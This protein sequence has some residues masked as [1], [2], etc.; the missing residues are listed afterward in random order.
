MEIK[1]QGLIIAAGASSHGKTT[2]TSGLAR[3]LVN[4]GKKVKIFKCGPDFLDPQ[5]HK[6]ASGVDCDNLDARMGTTTEITNRVVNACKYFDVI[7]FEGVMGLY[8]GNPSAADLA[9]MFKLPILLVI[10]ARAMAS[11][12]G[13]LAFGLKY[14]KGETNKARKYIKYVFANRVGS[15]NHANICRES[16]TSD[17]SQVGF[18]ERSQDIA[19]PEQHLGL[20]PANEII[21][22]DIKLN[23]LAKSLSEI[24]WSKVFEN[25]TLPP[26]TTPTP[27]LPKLLEN[28]TIAIA[29]DRAFCFIY[30]AN[31]EILK[32][33][34]AK[35]KYFSPLSATK[36]P[37]CN[38]LWLP[39]GYPEIY[40]PELADNQT[41]QNEI[42]K[43]IINGKPTLAECGG[44]LYCFE[45]LIDINNSPHNFLGIFAGV[46]KM[47]KK[48][49]G[50]GMITVDLPQNQNSQEQ[51][52]KISG[53]TFHYCKLD[54]SEKP[55]TISK[56]ENG[57]NSE[58]VYRKHNTI[59]SFMH[60]YFPSNPLAIAKI[61]TKT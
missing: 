43:H 31:I 12:F 60:F 7:L 56:K 10:D 39:G 11:A 33:L 8:D 21:N 32:N 3:Y 19:L 27:Q 42:K 20:L 34:G 57:E 52:E 36:L 47:Q 17:I 28:T 30:P 41:I 38:S 54:S 58:L 14:Y 46:S 9:Q 55:I 25:I 26:I 15:L 23:F 13:A 49:S 22:L 35:I 37:E 61:F 24:N 53:H 50:L 18:L 5:I 48:L 51:V 1:T 45:K 16:L 6:V 40:A 4:N 44:M 29:H 59:A 2:I